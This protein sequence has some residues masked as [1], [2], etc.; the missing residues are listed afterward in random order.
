MSSLADLNARIRS[1][2]FL[3][4]CDVVKGD[5]VLRTARGRWPVKFTPKKDDFAPGP[6]HSLGLNHIHRRE[7]ARVVI[8]WL[9]AG[10]SALEEEA[11]RS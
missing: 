11:R 4:R 7:I 8:A 9:A 2:T 3:A 1:I 10:G 5:L 6:L